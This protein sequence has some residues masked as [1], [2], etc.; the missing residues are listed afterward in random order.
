MDATPIYY[1][2]FLLV[3]ISRAAFRALSD[4]SDGVFFCENEL[5]LKAF[6]YFYKN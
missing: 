6:N 4:I 3:V 2:F 5:W 1:S